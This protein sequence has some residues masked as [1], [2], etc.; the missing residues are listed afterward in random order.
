MNGP[1]STGL[2]G[3]CLLGIRPTGAEGEIYLEDNIKWSTDPTVSWNDAIKS[4]DGDEE[5]GNKLPPIWG[6][7]QKTS[8]EIVAHSDSLNKLYKSTDYGKN[9]KLYR[10]I[11]VEGYGVTACWSLAY[12]KNGIFLAVVETTSTPIIVKSTDY[13][14]TWYSVLTLPADGSPIAT[15]LNFGSGICIAHDRNKKIYKTVDYGETWVQINTTT[16][17]FDCKLVKINNTDA[18]S[19][20]G[21]RFIKLSNYGELLSYLA[22]GPEYGQITSIKAVEING[23]TIMLA[24][25]V[26]TGKVLISTDYFQTYTVLASTGAVYVTDIDYRNGILLVALWY[27]SKLVYSDN[28]GETWNDVMDLNSNCFISSIKIL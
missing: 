26:P 19:A 13:G 23:N 1:L 28:F 12:L 10:T 7:E 6:F 21:Y 24:G 17:Y 27:P 25:T 16:D 15:V 5:L 8:S 11:L 3:I 9:W 4:S 20:C 2:T 22:V 14:E 18:I